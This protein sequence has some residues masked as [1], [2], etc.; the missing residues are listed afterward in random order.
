MGALGVGESH[1]R[2][3]VP[4]RP[5]SAEGDI[6]EVRL[7]AHAANG[8]LIDQFLRD[9][10]NKRTDRYGGS[11]VNRS[12]FL[13]DVVEAVAPNVPGYVFPRRILKTT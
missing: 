12:R 4:Q 9:H 11:I 1:L 3:V 2:L 5:P 13:F 8:Y 10:T 7:G 6:G